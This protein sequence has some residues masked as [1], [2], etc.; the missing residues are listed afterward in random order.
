MISL[1]S[2]ANE[3]E[4]AKIHSLLFPAGLAW[5]TRVNQRVRQAHVDTHVYALRACARACSRGRTCRKYSSFV[6]CLMRA[7]CSRIN[8]LHAIHRGTSVV[9]CSFCSLPYSFFLPY[10]CSRLCNLLLA[11]LFSLLLLSAVYR[12]CEINHP[13]DVYPNKGEMSVNR[14][15]ISA[16]YFA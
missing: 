15:T 12:E 5:H 3:R 16:D 2:M 7:S 6:R 9:Y 11:C 8:T 13:H 4:F 1:S 14:A 10:S